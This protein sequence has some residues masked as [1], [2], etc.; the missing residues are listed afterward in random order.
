MNR[1]E[2]QDNKLNTEIVEATS[3][4]NAL[5]KFLSNKG[6]AYKDIVKLTQSVN[7]QLLNQGIDPSTQIDYMVGKENS[8]VITNY[9]IVV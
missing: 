7:Q 3:A 8:F 4:L 1:Y 2:V 5:K 9:H 6:I